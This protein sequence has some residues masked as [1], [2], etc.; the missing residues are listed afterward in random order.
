MFPVCFLQRGKMSF[1][2]LSFLLCLK[3]YH[4]D[5][6]VFE[7]EMFSKTIQGAT[8]LKLDMLKC[9]KSSLCQTQTLAGNATKFGMSVSLQED[10]RKYKNRREVLLV[11]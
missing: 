6:S 8:N 7:P 1:F 10:F 5:M 2:A 9:V 11:S 4:A 3:R